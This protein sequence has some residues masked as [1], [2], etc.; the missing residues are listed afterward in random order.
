MLNDK[1]SEILF[2]AITI[3]RV[4]NIKSIKRIKQRLVSLFP[5]S[6]AAISNAITFWAKHR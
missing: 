5:G 6:D 2:A 4:E 3:A 1:E